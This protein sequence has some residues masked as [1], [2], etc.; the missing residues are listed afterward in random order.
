MS[1]AGPL[2]D[3][4]CSFTPVAIE[5]ALQSSTFVD[6]TNVA[7]HAGVTKVGSSITP[8]RSIRVGLTVADLAGQARD[9]HV[10]R[11][12]RLP[13]LSLTSA[14]GLA[15][16]HRSL[17]AGGFE[18]SL[19]VDADARPVIRADDRSYPVRCTSFRGWPFGNSWLVLRPLA[20]D[21]IRMSRET[22]SWMSRSA[23]SGEH[24]TSA[25]HLLL[26]S[27]L[28]KPSIRRFSTLAWRSLS[29]TPDRRC[30]NLALTST[31]SRFRSARSIAWWSIVSAWGTQVELVS[32][33]N[34]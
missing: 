11:A 14:Q 16:V 9:G 10:Q 34:Q 24:L 13:R 30:Q 8:L 27:L 32:S 22:K 18:R 6:S 17:V 7:Q 26:V 29:A 31:V 1:E 3:L 2:R 28:S 5:T 21:F 15:D 20:V 33:S 4:D 19:P 23:V 12:F 25:A